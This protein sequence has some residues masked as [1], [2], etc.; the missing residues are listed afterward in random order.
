[1]I[2]LIV[3]I[4]LFS[5]FKI[6]YE[7]G[8][9]A[10][11]TD[12]IGLIIAII[13]SFNLTEPFGNLLSAILKTPNKGLISFIAGII[14]F[15]CTFFIILAIG[16]GLELYSKRSE[17]LDKTNKWIGGILATAKTIIFWWAI[18]LLITIFPS[19]GY[20]KQ[21]ITDSYSYNIISNMNPYMISFFQY[22]F[23]ENINKQIRKIIK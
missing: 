10:E 6:G 8:I 23:P 3:I 20:F 14:V 5:L 13:A 18:F 16:Y 17:M 9:I 21:Y 22:V 4:S 1:M 7:R 2:D 11:L 19:K 15:F 12:I